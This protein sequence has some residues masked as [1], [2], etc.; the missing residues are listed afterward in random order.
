LNSARL[1][2]AATIAVLS[3]LAVPNVRAEFVWSDEFE[4]DVID[5]STSTYDV[6]GWG[7]GNGQFELDTA[8]HE[9]SNLHEVTAR[10]FQAGSKGAANQ[11]FID[12]SPFSPYEEYEECSTDRGVWTPRW[13][14]HLR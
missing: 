3:L 14:P 11:R 12:S 4:G 9:N 7:F 5:T 6:G 8:R 13:T 10:R 2:A 1:K